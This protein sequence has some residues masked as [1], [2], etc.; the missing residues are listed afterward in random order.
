MSTPRPTQTQTSELAELRARIRSGDLLHGAHLV[1]A[2][3]YA[4]WTAI[5][6]TP[7]L[8]SS[9]GAVWISSPLG[10]GVTLVTEL[11]AVVALACVAVQSWRARAVW[12][13]WILALA[14]GLALAWRK[15]VDVFDLVYVALALVLGLWWFREERPELT[16]RALEL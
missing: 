3:L 11:L 16:E 14:L 2:A 13:T 7:G 4:V 15:D 10:R 5:E 9:S 1:L 12:R 6:R 8:A